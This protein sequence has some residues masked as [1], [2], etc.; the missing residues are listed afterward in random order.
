MKSCTFVEHL[1]F[2]ISV[3]SIEKLFDDLRTDVISMIKNWKLET[4]KDENL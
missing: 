1:F 3:T 2:I 4:K